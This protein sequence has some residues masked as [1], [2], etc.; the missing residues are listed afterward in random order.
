MTSRLR[1]LFFSSVPRIVVTGFLVVVVLVAAGFLAGVFGLPSVEG[2]ENRFGAVNDSTTVIETNLTVD[3]PNPIGLRLGGLS[4]S[5]GVSMNDVTMATGA[6]KGIGVGSGQSTL[7]FETRMRNDRIP[8]WWVSHIRNGERTTLSV[9]ASVR[10]SLLG[11]SVSVPPIEREIETDIA[12]ALDSTQTRPID[13]DQ[14]LVSDPVLYLNETS[15][16]WGAV[17]DAETPIEMSFTLYNPKPYPVPIGEVGYDVSMNGIAVGSGESSPSVAI[18]PRAT[19]TVTTTTVIRNERL[20]EWWVSHL[21]RNQ[22]TDL[23]I[24][25]SARIDLSDAGGGTVEVPLDSVTHTIETDVFGNKESTG[26]AGG[27]ADGPTPT[28]GAGGGTATPASE[29]PTRTNEST[30]TE[31]DGLL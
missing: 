1:S 31:D 28:P 18:P 8:A 15:G 10:S 23:R 25:F 9:N 29:T 24:D 27:T 13:A 20:D 7:H 16:R 3:N 30:P 14:P 19:E 17:T 6:K 22:V 12:A 11:T 2:V 4:V 21:E 26:D 5:Y